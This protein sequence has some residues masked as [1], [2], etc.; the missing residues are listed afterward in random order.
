[1]E[2]AVLQIERVR[3]ALCWD[4]PS[5][6][7]WVEKLKT[8]VA[9]GAKYALATD[10]VTLFCGAV[11]TDFKHLKRACLHVL[12]HCLLGH[13]WRKG[14][15]DLSC[16]VQAW[17]LSEALAPET[18]AEASAQEFR[19]RLKYI[20]TLAETERVLNTD[21]YLI[22][23]RAELA[24]LIQLDS[25]VL[26]GSQSQN[27]QFQWNGEAGNAHMRGKYG[28]S[29][30]SKK[31]DW[32]PSRA[33]AQGLCEYLSR[34]AVLRENAREDAENFETSLYLYGLEHYGNIPLIEP[35]ESREERRLETLAVVID[36][37]GSRSRGLTQRFL[38]I[39]LGLLEES[40]LFFKRFNL[41][42]LQCDAQVQRDDA[43]SDL[44]GFHHYIE[45]LQIIGGG[46]TDFR[47]AFARIQEHILRGSLRG[48]KGVLFFSDGRGIFPSAPPEFETTFVFLKD[49][50]DAIDVPNWVHTLVLDAP[51]PVGN[52]YMEY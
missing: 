21:A 5:L 44:R 1:M 32:T 23:H 30:G 42:I 10:G 11:P 26:W 15:E 22:E 9:P 50:Y 16:D 18:A 51:R 17:L 49:R 4:H 31:L 6:A 40:G 8:E 7:K 46:G 52:E 2:E 3:D 27:L 13:P 28:L 41:R 43:V 33:D 19:N 38:D 12:A 36:T 34:Y 20:E 29:A 35:P 37:S 24:Q 14:A 47:P 25:H 39:L 45:N 48:L